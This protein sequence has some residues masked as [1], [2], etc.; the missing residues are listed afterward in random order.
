VTIVR[1]GRRT[2]PG[3]AL[4][5][6][7][8]LVCAGLLLLARP[9]P[10]F[11]SHPLA[12]VYTLGPSGDGDTA[13]AHRWTAGESRA[14]SRESSDADDDSDAGGEADAVHAALGAELEVGR[15]IAAR[16]ADDHFS[17]LFSLASIS[18]SL[19]APPRRGFPRT[20]SRSMRSVSG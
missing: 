5:A 10:V 13:A 17:T 15:A 1:R 18:H 8:I 6:S 20:S 7:A 3:L 9:V 2:E 16:L 11:D 12:R 4:L 14:S 19:R